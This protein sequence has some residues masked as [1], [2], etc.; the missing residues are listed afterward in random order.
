[1]TN[2]LKN[3]AVMLA[4][5]PLLLM[6]CD[7]QKQA[8]APFSVIGASIPEM[9]AAM[10]AGRT[11]S[12][13]IVLQYLARIAIYNDKLHGA[14][15]VDPAVLATADAL[16]RE[17][18]EGKV[19]GPLHGIPVAVKDNI[20]TT[21]MPSSGGALAFKDYI[22]PYEAT[23]V[24]NLREAGAIVMAKSTL[25]ELANWMAAPPTPM[26]GGYNAVRGYSY[27]PY[28]PRAKDNGEPYLS[29][30]GSSSGI[31]V[32]AEFWAAN[33]GTDT[34]GSVVNPANASM[35]VGL[36]PTTGR[37]SRWGIIPI[38]LDQDSA[39]PM[40]KTVMDVAIMM[41]ALE[42]ATPD[43]HDDAT[44]TCAPPPGR[45]YTQYLKADA[46]K[47]ARI[48]IPRT[49]YYEPS[50]LPGTPAP[51]RGLR[52]DEAEAMKGA[53]EVLKAQGA[54]V[55][56]PADLPSVTSADPQNNILVRQICGAPAFISGEEG[57]CSTV[58]RYGMKRDF[59]AFLKTLGAGAPV[60]SLTE[61]RTWNSEHAAPTNGSMGAIRYGQRQLDLADAIDLEKDKARYEEDRAR[62]LRLSRDEGM[63][64]PIKANNLDVLMFPGSG[65]TDIGT[66]AG[67]PAIAVPYAMVGNPNGP[68]SD[69]ADAKTRPFGV[70]FLGLACTE[71]RLFAIAY[72]FE[73]VTRKRIPPKSTP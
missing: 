65:A 60:K 41:G 36:R 24:T 33:V 47:G 64:A 23:L 30:G 45:D 31:G 68:A 51:S 9:Q 69:P 20:L 4:V 5:L 19:R 46:L 59:N 52:P 11:T 43:S 50:Q 53:I 15:T 39:G 22:P 42:G 26:E 17:R 34:G 2:P 3:R 40:G 13:D 16:D 21:S 73:Q 27:N 72:A 63:D 57:V 55:V 61:L 66:K 67:Y 62:D 12:R 7:Q 18:R 70:S 38:T 1:M 14:V 48:G 32:S 54:T 10:K 28:D 58:L 29:T 44:K 25:T 6:S 35:Q 37:I 56:D 49:S 8:Q 71:P